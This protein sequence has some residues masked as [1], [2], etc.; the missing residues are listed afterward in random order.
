MFRSNER[1][2]RILIGFYVK[3]LC[4]RWSPR[5]FS[6]KLEF[7]QNGI[8]EVITPIVFELSLFRFLRQTEKRALYHPTENGS[9]N[10]NKLRQSIY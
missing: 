3:R 5:T 1:V 8:S 9:R 7:T 6:V 4:T 10:V 2:L